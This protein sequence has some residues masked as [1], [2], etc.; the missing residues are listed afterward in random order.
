MFVIVEEIVSAF[1]PRAMVYAAVFAGFGWI[2]LAQRM[3]EGF[4]G[5]FFLIGRRFRGGIFGFQGAR[6]C[7]C[8]AVWPPLGNGVACGAVP[9][10]EAEGWGVGVAVTRLEH[11]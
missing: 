3:G 1:P 11:G 4:R 9:W 5:G 10:G 6:S 7:G 8:V 2:E